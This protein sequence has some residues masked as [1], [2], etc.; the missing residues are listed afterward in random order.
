MPFE[1]VKRRSSVRSAFQPRNAVDAIRGVGIRSGAQ[2]AQVTSA[3]SGYGDYYLFDAAVA[4][5]ASPMNRAT[6]EVGAVEA[7]RRAI[8]AQ[9]RAQGTT[10]ARTM[11]RQITDKTAEI[12]RQ[13]TDR[14]MI[15]FTDRPSR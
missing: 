10:D 14:Y 5:S 15:E 6:A 12:R 8:R 1:I 9:E 11:M 2:S 4:Y 13:M 3:Y 7:Q